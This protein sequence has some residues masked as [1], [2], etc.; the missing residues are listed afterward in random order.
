MS[1]VSIAMLLLGVLVVSALGNTI[2]IP[3]FSATKN[4]ETLMGGG[5]LTLT[6]RYSRIGSDEVRSNFIDF[7]TED[8]RIFQV[9]FGA[10]HASDAPDG[11]F[12]LKMYTK[13]ADGE[14]YSIPSKGTIDILKT[15]GTSGY[16]L[17][18]GQTFT[19]RNSESEFYSLLAR[20]TLI[21][22]K[23]GYYDE[24]NDSLQLLVIFNF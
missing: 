21:D 19:N 14:D 18:W 4:E 8:D 10:K 5:R 17:K 24:S 7:S 16:S 23:N 3:E 2:R 13:V 22:P 12:Q 1:P 6:L 15:S 9:G 20:S 11:K